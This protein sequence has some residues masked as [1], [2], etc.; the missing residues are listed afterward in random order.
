MWVWLPPHKL[1][2]VAP[3]YQDGGGICLSWP[4]LGLMVVV[5]ST[6]QMRASGWVASL[7][8][9]K[10]S[11]WFS[12]TVHGRLLRRI[13]SQ[14]GDLIISWICTSVGSKWMHLDVYL[15]VLLLEIYSHPGFFHSLFIM[16]SILLLVSIVLHLVILIFV[17]SSYYLYWLLVY[18]LIWCNL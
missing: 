3:F 2:S 12:S 8:L 10:A 5:S 15:N 16:K 1:S 18:H 4:F 6:W 9:G 11:L 14:K 7:S 17:F 13:F